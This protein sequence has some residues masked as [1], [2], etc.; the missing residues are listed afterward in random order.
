MT[1]YLKLGTLFP[2]NIFHPSFIHLSIHLSKIHLSIYLS[3][4]PS[5]YLSIHLPKYIC[6]HP[7]IYLSLEWRQTNNKI[8]W[9]LVIP[10]GEESCDLIKSA[11]KFKVW[12]SSNWQLQRKFYLQRGMCSIPRRMISLRTSAL[13]PILIKWLVM[14][15]LHKT[16]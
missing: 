9:A 1:S 2:E 6:F 12:V 13:F 7:S 14:H 15:M 11:A 10:L 16:S 5:T 4:Y 8:P 3:F